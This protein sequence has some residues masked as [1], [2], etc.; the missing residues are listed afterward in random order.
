M[1][2]H[3]FDLPKNK[4]RVKTFVVEKKL[5]LEVVKMDSD[6]VWILI[7]EGS[8]MHSIHTCIYY[9]VLQQL[10][11]SRK[12]VKIKLVFQLKNDRPL[13]DSC[14]ASHL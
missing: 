4:E 6:L 3:C 7:S 11:I 9:Q 14:G 5:K 12:I 1:S 13:K 10:S 2:V 8:H